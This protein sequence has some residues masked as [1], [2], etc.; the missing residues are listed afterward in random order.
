[1]K[2]Q[3][4]LRV[5]SSTQLFFIKM[6]AGPSGPLCQNGKKIVFVVRHVQG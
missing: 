6:E 2:E 1:M 3:M 4:P 5:A